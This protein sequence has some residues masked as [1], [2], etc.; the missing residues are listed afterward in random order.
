MKKKAILFT[1]ALLSTLTASAYDACIGGIYYNFDTSAKTATVT[2]SNNHYTGSVT[3]PETVEYNGIT[4]SVISIGSYAFGNCSGLTEV[5]I[6]NSVTS[7]GESAFYECS[8]LT[9]VT[10]P[11][12][13]TTIGDKAF[14]SCSGLTEVTIGNSVTS[15]GIRSSFYGCTTLNEVK[16]NSNDVVSKTYYSTYSLKDIF[17]EQVKEYIIG[18]NVTSIGEYAFHNCSNLKSVTIPNSVTSIGNYSFDGCSGL[19]EVHITDIA[20]WCN[21]TFSDSYSSNP[22]Y[23]A[24]HLFMDGKELTDLVIPDGVMSIGKGAFIGCSSLTSVTIPNSMTEIGSYAFGQCSGL[25]EVHI[26]DLETWCKISF[27]GFVTNPLFWAKHLFMDGKEI[28]DLII[29]NSVTSIGNNAFEGCSGLT[30]VT[31][32]N[33]VTSIGQSAFFGCSSLTSITIPHSVTSIGSSAFSG[34]TGNIKVNCD[35]PSVSS[36][37]E[38]P[39]YES[40]FSQLEI[41]NDVKIIGDNAFKDCTGLITITIGS[42]VES[43]GDYAFNNIQKLDKIYCYAQSVPTTSRNTFENSYIDYATLYVP[44]S[45]LDAY[46]STAPWKSAASILPLEDVKEKCAI[47]TIIFENGKLSFSCETEGV[48]YVYNFSTPSEIDESGSNISM[49]KTIQVSV[50]AQKEGFDNSDTATMDIDVSSISSSIK[51]DVNEDGTVNGTD[52]QEVINIIVD[53]E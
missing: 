36:E 3:I 52:I 20:A 45:S 33:S 29:P 13:V 48:R 47:P 25:R 15:I 42:S 24:H 28:K 53:G 37:R 6:G 1:L 10:I 18:E 43:L 49:S 17:G 41:G 8:N 34:C 21:I 44:A 7:I 12:S 38:R 19:T 31:I 26:S 16:I 2:S 51:G 23:Y 30:S 14:M 11:N 27:S 50:C 32:P 4:Y 9:S 46:K 40:N 39:F 35:I 5:T 22:L